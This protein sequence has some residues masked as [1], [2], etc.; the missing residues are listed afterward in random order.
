MCR[1]TRGQIQTPMLIKH[2]FRVVCKEQSC[3]LANL[4]GCGCCSEGNT[5]GRC[6]CCRHSGWRST[7]HHGN[8]RKEN[9]ISKHTE[10]CSRMGTRATRGGPSSMGHHSEKPRHHGQRVTC[11]HRAKQDNIPEGGEGDEREKKGKML[12]T[13]KSRKSTQTSLTVSIQKSTGEFFNA[14]LFTNFCLLKIQ[15]KYLLQTEINLVQGQNTATWLW[16]NTVFS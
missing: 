2:R 13:I 15:P 10:E 9:Q 11:N 4:V 1:P 8:F 14:L 6:C 16:Q 12:V 5:C 3:K 7:V